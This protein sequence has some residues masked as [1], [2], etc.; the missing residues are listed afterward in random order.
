MIKFKIPKIDS[1]RLIVPLSDVQVLDSKFMQKFVLLNLD[2]GEI[3]TET[4]HINTS[5][6]SNHNGIK[7][8]FAMLYF[9]NENKEQEQCLVIGINAK[10]LK[11]NYFEGINKN[12]IETIFNYINASGYIK[13]EKQ[14]FLN[15]K[16]TDVDFCIDFKL[17]NITCKDVFSICHELTIP[18]KT[19]KPNLFELKINRGI[20]WGKRKE[21]AKAYKTKQF[22][23]YYA[24]VLEL[25]HNSTD[26]YNAYI[27]DKLNEETLFAD[28]SIFVPDYNENNILRV[29]TT[30]KNSDHFNTYGIKCKTLIELLN[31]D[32]LKHNAI[33]NRPIQ[34]YMSGYKTITHNLELTLTQRGWIYSL[35]LLA[36]SMN[37]RPI[38][39]VDVLV[40]QMFPFNPDTK[41]NV[42]KSSRSQF[43]KKLIELL[44]IDKK[45]MIQNKMKNTQI[46][47]D[48][49]KGFGII[50]I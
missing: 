2:S 28:S 43:K 23:K 22:L 33:F 39:V 50:P 48:E 8:G 16:V 36:K 20:E 1:F 15:A 4:E 38:E 35:N 27:K 31:I 5:N 10:M 41:I 18:S 46:S 30:I 12:T 44:H 19:I 17:T 3:Y 21:V 25:M 29:E 26:F 13:I 42:L 24:K 32:L 37:L 11:S 40:L 7:L 49:I 14:V 34:T 45:T 6:F 9:Y 47:M